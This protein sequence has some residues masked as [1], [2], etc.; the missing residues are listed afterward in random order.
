MSS[1]LCGGD[2]VGVFVSDIGSYTMRAGYAVEDCPK[3]D[4][5]TTTGEVLESG[6]ILMEIDGGKGK[7]VSPTYYIDTNALHVPGE[8]MEVISPLKNRMIENWDRFQ[9]I[10]DHTYKIRV[11]SE[12]SLHP[13]LTSEV[14]WNTRVKR[15]KL[16]EMIFEHYNIPAFF[17]CKT[18][19]LTTCA[20]GHST[21]LIWDTGVSHTTAIPVH[22]G[23]VLQERIVKSPLAGDF[24]TMQCR[25]QEMN[26]ELIPPYTIASKAVHE[27]SSANWNFWKKKSLSLC[28]SGPLLPK[29]WGNCPKLQ[30]FFAAVFR[31]N[32]GD[33]YVFGSSKVGAD[34]AAS[35]TAPACP[36][37]P[38]FPSWS[39]GF[40][41]IVLIASPVPALS[42]EAPPKELYPSVP[43]G[44]SLSPC[45]TGF[46]TPIDTSERGCDH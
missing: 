4:F 25:K 30:F 15:E 44:V 34:L 8:N 23:Y 9:T 37:F 6:S 29:W 19:V 3:V 39:L 36:S 11:K 13:V 33:L 22:D 32:F 16:T 12:A 41:A 1:T 5:P 14:P 31:D 17:L 26:V 28:R 43:A 2:E 27:G 46:S 10:L 7:Q 38:S 20:N 40:R 35:W 45:F 21:G 18:A 24:I 42:F